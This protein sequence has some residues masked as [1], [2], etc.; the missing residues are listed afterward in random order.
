M[1]NNVFMYLFTIHRFILVTCRFRFCCLY[2]KNGSFI[3]LLLNRNFLNM[4]SGNKPSFRFMIYKYF[5]PIC[6]LPF[7]F[8]LLSLEEQMILNFGG[9]QYIIFCGLC[10]LSHS[11]T[12][13]FN[14]SSQRF[15]SIFFL[16]VL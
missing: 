12:S 10:F 13:L 11:G 5:L 4:C 8:L 2:F 9:V 16:N 6:G 1:I 14:L 15:S 3:F 7:H